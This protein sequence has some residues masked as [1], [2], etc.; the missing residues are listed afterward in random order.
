MVLEHGIAGQVP[1]WHLPSGILPVAVEPQADG[2]GLQAAG[3]RARKNLGSLPLLPGSDGD[4]SFSTATD[5]FR[6][7]L[8]QASLQ[9]PEFTQG[10]VGG[11]GDVAAQLALRGVE[12]ELFRG[13]CVPG[14]DGPLEGAPGV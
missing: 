8:L 3:S 13:G 5:T 1:S 9:Q 2:G 12:A 14:A 6:F 11:G 4:V 7:R 10:Q